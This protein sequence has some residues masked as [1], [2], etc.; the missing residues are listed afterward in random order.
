MQTE[1]WHEC[2][3]ALDQIDLFSFLSQ[4]GHFD[5]IE[6]YLIGTCPYHHGSQ[7]SLVVKPKSKDFHC[8]YSKCNARGSIIKLIATYEKSDIDATCAKILQR[9]VVEKPSIQDT[10]SFVDQIIDQKQQLL[11]EYNQ[12]QLRTLREC[13]LR[14]WNEYI[15]GVKVDRQTIET[16]IGSLI[17][18]ALQKFYQLPQA[19]KRQSDLTLLF[20][21]GWGKGYG[22]QDDREYWLEKAQTALQNAQDLNVDLKPIKM[23]ME[24]TRSTTFPFDNPQYKLKSKIDRVDWYGDLEYCLI[25]YKWD[26]KTLT[27]EEATNDFQT[28]LY[29]LTWTAN[30]QGVSPKLISYQFLTYG[31]QV[32]VTPIVTT[33]ESGI[34]NLIHY[35]EKAENLKGLTTEPEATRNKYCYSCKLYGEC[36]ATK[37]QVK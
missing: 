28:V 22:P 6:G 9:M 8:V 5:N 7:K 32:D 37:G 1:I 34:E 33:M 14:Y 25:D 36:P 11:P 16:T 31:I 2:E 29:Y 13:P 35:I 24:I 21:K 20:T 10:F 18:S 4:Y 12:T 23:E 30:M 27:E 17:H 19:S 26:E 3:N 15:R